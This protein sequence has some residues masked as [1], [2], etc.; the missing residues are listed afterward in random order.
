MERRFEQIRRLNPGGVTI[1]KWFDI[2]GDDIRYLLKD[3][4]KTNKINYN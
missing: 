2:T 1:E 3:F 4:D